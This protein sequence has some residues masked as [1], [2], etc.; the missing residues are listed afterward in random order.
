MGI[1][2]APSRPT[3]AA[4]AGIGAATG[5]LY[6]VIHVAQKALLDATI[7]APGPG[8]SV[9]DNPNNY[10]ELIALLGSYTVACLG[11]LVLYDRLLLWSRA[12]GWSR[13]S[14]GLALGM[15]VVLYMCLWLTIPYFSTDLLTYASYG[16]IA[17]SGGNPY[18]QSG[19]TIL[20]TTFGRQLAALGWR[21]SPAPTPYG[22]VWTVLSA[23]AVGLSKD[24]AGAV[25]II[26]GVVV[27]ATLATALA[28][29]WLL[30]AVDIRYRL[31]GTL[32]LLWNPA[33]VVLLASEG[34]NDAV[35]MFL[36]VLSLGFSVRQF[37]IGGC[38]TQLV[39]AFTKYFS[40]VLLPLQVTF[41]W[42]TRSN[43]RNLVAQMAASIVLGVCLAALLYAP[44]WVGINTFFGTGALGNGQPTD[45]G[46]DTGWRLVPA[47]RF[48]LV[49]L[50]IAIGMW[51]SSSPTRLMEACAGVALVALVGGPQRFWPWYA[52]VP[53]ALMA[54]TPALPWRWL[55]LVV[56]ACMLLAS[57]IEALPIGGQG[58]IGFEFQTLV[59]RSVRLLPLVALSATLLARSVALTRER[60]ES[61][62]AAIPNRDWLSVYRRLPTLSWRRTRPSS[63]RSAEDPYK[64]R[65]KIR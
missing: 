7:A 14:R 24:A 17:L 50:A 42:R 29:W 54:L 10:G 18:S 8:P 4:I 55:L 30:S 65:L 12:D 25:W 28:G 31:T 39:A 5:L 21:G 52:C 56:S 23:A 61:P 36:V 3:P 38:V 37:V 45:P 1:R 63:T 40:V 16:S 49:A 13:F 32:A 33:L 60:R 62:R 15:P 20:T 26:K 57:P 58:L 34:H 35:M 9:W 22:P 43:H 59:F 64:D 19:D 48:L 44:F 41:W 2:L 51:H 6:F 11:L 53:L 46:F 27:S 47:A